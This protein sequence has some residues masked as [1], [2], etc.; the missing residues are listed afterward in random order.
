MNK[1]LTI[2]PHSAPAFELNK[3]QTDLQAAFILK[4]SDSTFFFTPD[5]MAMIFQKPLQS[6]SSELTKTRYPDSSAHQREVWGLRLHFNGAQKEVSIDGQERL[7]GVKNYFRGSEPSLWHTD[8]PTFGKLSY[9]G[10]Y[11][12]IDM[13]FYFHESQLEFDFMIAPGAHP[14]HIS[15]EFEGCDEIK[16]GEEG[17]LFIFVDSHFILLKAPSIYQFDDLGNKIPLAGG[18]IRRENG[19]IGFEVCDSYNLEAPLVIDPVLAYSTFLGGNDTSEGLGITVDNSGSAYVT[20]YTFATNFPTQGPIQGSLAGSSDVFITKFSP[21]GNTL[22]YST[23]LGGSNSDQGTSIAVDIAGN[24]YV[25]GFTSS[26]DFPVLNAYQ[27]VAPAN[28]NAFI[29]QINASGSTLLYSTYL[30]GG[31]I[32]SG[33]GIAVDTLGNIYVTG[34]T[35]S[36]DF[37]LMNPFQSSFSFVNTTF[38][39]KLVPTASP[40]SQLIYSTYFGGTTLATGLAVDSADQAIIA[41]YTA[42]NVIPIVNA[43]QPVFGGGSLDAFVAKF[44][45]SGTALVYSTYIGGNDDDLAL[46]MALDLAG[47]VYVTG[48]T[49]STN[50]P[51]SNPVQA[52]LGGGRDAFVVKLNASGSA[53]I[54][55]TYLGG[56]DDE[57]GYAVATDPFGSTYVTGFTLSNNFPLADPFQATYPGG[58]SIF[59]TKLNPIGG[60]IYSTYFAG[61]FGFSIAADSFGS[62]Y[63]TG[64][65]SG[66]NFPLENPFQSTIGADSAFVSKLEDTTEFGPT[67][68]TGP[69]GPAGPTGAT[70]PPGSNGEPGPD[71]AEGPISPTGPT[72]GTGTTGSQGVAGATG[73]QGAAGAAGTTGPAGALGPAGPAGSIGSAGVTGLTGSDGAAGPA[74][75]AGSAGA[76]GNTGPAGTAGSAGPRGATGSRG[77]AGPRGPHGPHGP[78]GPPGRNGS[79]IEIV[80]TIKIIKSCNRHGCRPYS[81]AM[82]LARRLEKFLFQDAELC[83]LSPSVAAIVRLMKKRNYKS[84]VIRLG[85][86][87]TRFK[88]IVEIEDIPSRKAKQVLKLSA[89]LLNELMRLA[90]TG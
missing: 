21:A 25:T 78:Q 36:S 85:K 48:Y 53:F 6:G 50:F 49:F 63:V 65:T 22:I 3:G 23:Y 54:Y 46:G 34:V 55:S 57:Q 4:T 67:G 41:G 28:Q 32:D 76:V 60:F 84:A 1:P 73:P 86:F 75:T 38:L 61:N 79:I 90:A 56:S 29:S 27:A 70:G 10:L 68:P 14:N 30:G 77:A 15:L 17:Q 2:T 51:I 72:G 19:Q 42:N 43:V 9:T 8:V 20:G 74:G 7:D 66:T 35:I 88:E 45:P 81:E 83:F 5:H 12:G 52:A 31:D 13:L 33:A 26:A 24:A 16:I 69:P 11:P 89:A 80:E 44:T 64:S 58:F 59:I 47:N 40:L 87:M 82:R 37:P 39:T 71:G 62:A 18:Y